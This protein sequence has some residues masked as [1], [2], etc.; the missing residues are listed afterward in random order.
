MSISLKNHYTSTI[1][2]H[3]YKYLERITY[4]ESE[5]GTQMLPSGSELYLSIDELNPDFYL[6]YNEQFKYNSGSNNTIIIKAKRTDFTGRTYFYV[7]GIFRPRA[8]ILKGQKVDL[9]V[10]SSGTQ[11]SATQNYRCPEVGYPQPVAGHN[12]TDKEFKRLINF[13]ITNFLETDYSYEVHWNNDTGRD[14]NITFDFII[15]VDEAEML[16]NIK[17]ANFLNSQC[18]S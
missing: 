9:V 7:L 11:L 12:I 17:A 18:V 8:D 2:I 6:E 16:M 10:R 14:L 5:D 4:K 1:S 15:S 13:S 3:T